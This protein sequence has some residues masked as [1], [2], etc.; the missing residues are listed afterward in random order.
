MATASV[1]LI[2]AETRERAVQLVKDLVDAEVL[3]MKQ[4]A[5]KRGVTKKANDQEFKA[6][7]ELFAALT[8]SVAAP[9]EMDRMC[10]S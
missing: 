7:R 8:G 1:P 4:M 3:I 6:V 10:G 2:A 5:T 9:E